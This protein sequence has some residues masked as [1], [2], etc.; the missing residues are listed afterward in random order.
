MR[1]ALLIC[2]LSGISFAIAA[3]F[4][5]QELQYA[6]AT[7]I[8]ATIKSVAWGDSMNVRS[9][10]ADTINPVFLHFYNFDCPC[11]RFNIQEFRHLVN[12]YRDSIQFIAVVEASTNS[13]QLIK[14]FQEKFELDIPVVVDYNGTIAREMG[15]YSTPQAVLLTK[16]HKLY[17]KGNYNKARYCTAKNTRFAEQAIVDLLRGKDSPQIMMMAGLAYGCSLPA[18]DV[19]PELALP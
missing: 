8:P 3:L 19:V 2:I 10:P 15:V 4:W 6:Q 12:M 11:S 9:L 7:P 18:D 14:R 17:Y 13:P 16:D 1:L 5:N